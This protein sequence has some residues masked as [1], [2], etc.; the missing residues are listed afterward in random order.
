MLVRPGLDVDAALQEDVGGA[1]DV[2]A[3]VGGVPHVEADGLYRELLSGLW[4]GDI[5][6]LVG[7]LRNPVPIGDVVQEPLFGDRLA[8]V[9]RPGHPL[10]VAR[11]LTPEALAR[12][13]WVV[14]RAGA[15]TRTQIDAFFAD[16]PEGGP[17]SLIEAGSILFMREYLS[18]G[19]VLG[20]ISAAQADA[21]IAKVLLI[22]LDVRAD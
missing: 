4:R 17:E 3:L 5:D 11:G 22:A 16:L 9:A 6:L 13:A 15:P 14:P 10:A 8:V 21:E 12:H 1:Q 2:L 20:C 7:A 19:D 18:L